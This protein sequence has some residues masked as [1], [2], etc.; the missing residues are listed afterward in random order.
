MLHHLAIVIVYLS[1]LNEEGK[2]NK[3]SSNLIVMQD[4]HSIVINLTSNPLSITIPQ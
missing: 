3:T 2:T 1:R 4:E